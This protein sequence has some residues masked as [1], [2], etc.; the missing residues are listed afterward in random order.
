MKLQSL[1][2]LSHLVDA[3]DSSR[4][5]YLRR[6]SRDPGNQSGETHLCPARPNQKQAAQCV[7]LVKSLVYSSMQVAGFSPGSYGRQQITL[8]HTP[9]DVRGHRLLQVD[10]L[11]VLA[12]LVTP[13]QHHTRQVLAGH[14]SGAGNPHQSLPAMWKRFL[15]PLPHRP[16]IQRKKWRMSVCRTEFF[17]PPGPPARSFPERA[18]AGLPQTTRRYRSLCKMG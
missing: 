17:L 3:G 1:S 16:I 7:A 4:S 18:L 5:Y 8:S 12:E 14:S 11:G 9:L 13:S 2:R 10:W 15:K 6:T